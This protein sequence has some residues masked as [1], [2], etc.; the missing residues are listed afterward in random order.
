MLVPY[1]VVPH[2]TPTQQMIADLLNIAPLLLVFAI[3]AW[4]GYVPSKH[5]IAFD[6]HL[7][8]LHKRINTIDE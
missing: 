8:G 5:R 4:A 1:S 7:G 3:N 6:V 2:E